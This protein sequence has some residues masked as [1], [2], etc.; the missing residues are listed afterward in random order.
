MQAQPDDFQS[1]TQKPTPGPQFFLSFSVAFF[2]HFHRCLHYSRRNRSFIFSSRL[3]TWQEC[4]T[5]RIGDPRPLLEVPWNFPLT[6]HFARTGSPAEDL[7]WVIALGVKRQVAFNHLISASILIRWHSRTVLW[8]AQTVR[9]RRIPSR[10]KLSVLGRLCGSRQ[11]VARNHLPPTRV[12]N[13]ISGKLLLAA[14][15]PRVCKYKSNLWVSIGISGSRSR[16]SQQTP[17]M[18][19]L[20]RPRPDFMTNANEDTTS[21]YGKRSQI[22]STAC[23]S[24]PSVSC[25]R[26]SPPLFAANVRLSF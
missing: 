3:Q 7:R 11:A 5:H 16:V 24:P 12:Q 22:A 9:V 25:S 19:F 6:A 1:T 18:I 10:V 26:D 17:K 8:L 4:T 23:P 21:S 20:P 2:S 15:Q 14:R 13:Q